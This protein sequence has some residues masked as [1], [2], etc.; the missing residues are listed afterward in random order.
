MVF[1]SPS[2]RRRADAASPSRHLHQRISFSY[3]ARLLTHCHITSNLSCIHS[4]PRSPPPIAEA[5]PSPP[6]T[7]APALALA[8]IRVSGRLAAAIARREMRDPLK[9]N[10]RLQAQHLHVLV[11]ALPSGPVRRAPPCAASLGWRQRQLRTYLNTM[12]PCPLDRSRSAQ[13]PAF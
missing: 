8:T 11:S 1:Q 13:T 5:L 12:N 7:T 2:A 9:L 4:F 3:T 10:W 6:L